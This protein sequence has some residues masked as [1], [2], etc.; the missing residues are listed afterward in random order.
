MFFWEKR[1][2]IGVYKIIRIRRQAGGE[3]ILDKND[4]EERLVK[5]SYA[6]QC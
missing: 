4:R 3:V 1:R 2:L 5:K 6:G